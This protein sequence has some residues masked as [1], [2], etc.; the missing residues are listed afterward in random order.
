MHQNF[1]KR[2]NLIWS[3]YWPLV[4][5]LLFGGYDSCQAQ[6]ENYLQELRQGKYSLEAK[7]KKDDYSFILESMMY[8]I[9]LNQDGGQE[10]IIF[11]QR[12]GESWLVL[13]NSQGR[14]LGE[15]KFFVTGRYAAPVRLHLKT[16]APQVRVLGV[17]FKEGEN[18]YTEFANT[19][20]WYFLVISGDN[21]EKMNFVPGPLMAE[22]HLDA[23]KRYYRRGSRLLF[24]D[25][26]Q[27]GVLDVIVSFREIKRAYI[28]R[29]Y[30][31][32]PIRM[33]L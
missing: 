27:D 15:F 28:F 17:A 23:Q 7:K 29:H 11:E 22:E 13:Y 2:Q 10:G 16:L 19:V 1:L 12:D 33:N 31:L 8:D 3:C 4:W 24:E 25:L 20:R 18:N 14:K 9:D 30:T 32:E 5:S 21:F 6:D 26:N